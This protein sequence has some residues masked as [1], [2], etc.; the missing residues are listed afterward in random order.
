MS[1]DYD[2]YNRGIILSEDI[3]FT[4][5]TARLL[6]EPVEDARDMTYRWLKID[7][8]QQTD[9]NYVDSDYDYVAYTFYVKNDGL[10]TVDITYHLRMTEVYRNM[11]EAI[12]ILII[13]DDVET[14]YQKIDKAD[15]EGNFPTYPQ[16]MPDSKL[17]V[18]DSVIARESFVKFEPE[19]TKKF[20]VIMW[21][22]GYDPDTTDA[23]IGG[24]I[25]LQMNFSIDG[26]K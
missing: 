5:P 21:L 8:A 15:K 19:Q 16:S 11:D 17:F 22:E 2:A 20:T 1:M 6:T 14:M 3:A 4:N 10:E 25:K 26:L 23:I 9:G 24:R 18:N 7:E 12:R 13:E